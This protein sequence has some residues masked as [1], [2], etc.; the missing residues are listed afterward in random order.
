[1]VTS[2]DG[3]AGP[4]H[5]EA[6]PAG[7]AEADAEP[8]RLDATVRAGLAAGPATEPQAQT[9]SRTTAT[10]HAS[11]RIRPA[12]PAPTSRSRVSEYPEIRGNR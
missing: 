3:A 7:V 6:A 8:A 11:A 5:S 9:A 2:R 4:P 10:G 1:M 12:C